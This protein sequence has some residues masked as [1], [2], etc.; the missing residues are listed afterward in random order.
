MIAAPRRKLVTRLRAIR[1]ALGLDVV[2]I[3]YCEQPDGRLLVFEATP[4]A[5]LILPC[6][7]GT[8]GAH[9]LG[10]V[11]RIAASLSRLVATGHALEAMHN[12]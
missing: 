1:D 10:S 6:E 12:G 9:V 11:A 2:T 3:D 8:E 4:C 5:R 7:V